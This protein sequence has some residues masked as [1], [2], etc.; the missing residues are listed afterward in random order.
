MPVLRFTALP[1][2]GPQV[3]ALE[4]LDAKIRPTL[5]LVDN[6]NGGADRTITLRDRFTPDISNGVPAPVLTNVDKFTATWVITG[7]ASI[8]DELKDLEILGD[9][10]CYADAVDAN[11]IITLGYEFIEN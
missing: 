10:L 8:Q 7:C 11:C 3:V 9:L 2:A 1:V 5:L 6:T 4:R